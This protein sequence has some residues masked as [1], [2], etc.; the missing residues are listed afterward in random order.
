[1]AA[2]P[3]SVIIRGHST[4]TENVRGGCTRKLLLLSK[5]LREIGVDDGKYKGR[6][7]N[8]AI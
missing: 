2:G 1:M 3:V 8:L 5:K 4:A 6:R 7:V